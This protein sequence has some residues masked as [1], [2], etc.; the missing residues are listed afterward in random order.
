M[1]NCR[2]VFGFNISMP[3]LQTIFDKYNSDKKNVDVCSKC[4]IK[5]DKNYRFCFN[6]GMNLADCV[7]TNAISLIDYDMCIKDAINMLSKINKRLQALYDILPDYKG[8]KLFFNNDKTSMLLGLNIGHIDY[9]FNIS[10]NISEIDDTIRKSGYGCMLDVFFP[11]IVR[12]YS[13]FII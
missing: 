7:N 13:L 6:C 1:Q 10:K 2:L 12:D 8:V 5:N 11:E 3:A 9:P 4:N